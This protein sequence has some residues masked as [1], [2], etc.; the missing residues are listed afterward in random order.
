MGSNRIRDL[1]RHYHT[2]QVQK[3]KHFDHNRNRKNGRRKQED[4]RQ[5]EEKQSVYYRPRN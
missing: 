3:D 1:C 5:V 4:T 2:N